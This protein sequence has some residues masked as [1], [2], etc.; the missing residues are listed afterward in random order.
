[1]RAISPKAR[2]W[3][4]AW[5]RL[6]DSTRCEW[7]EEGAYLRSGT[8]DGPG[9][10]DHDEAERNIKECAPDCLRSRPR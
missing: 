8:Y 4:V 3:R 5:A 2:A 1:V 10:P 7:G 9:R 6:G